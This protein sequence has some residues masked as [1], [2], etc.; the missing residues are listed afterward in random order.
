MIDQENKS[1]AS[2]NQANPN[3]V[4]I[5]DTTLRDGEQ[6]PG[7]SMNIREKIEVGH[8]LARLGVD[9]IEAG[10]PITSPGDFEAVQ[11]IAREIEGPTICALART[12]EKDITRAGEAVAPAKNRRI[13][14]FIAT[15]DVHVEKKLRMSREQVI[16]NA[17]AAV[18]LARTFTDDVE[19]SCE[20]AGRTDWDYMVEVLTAVI[21]AGATTLNIPDTVGY[22]VPEQ[23]GKCIEYVRSKTPGIENCIVSVHCHNDL[24]MAVANTLAGL[25]H[26]ARQAECTVNGIGERAGNA[27]L[28]EIVMMLRVRKDYWGLETGIKTEEIYRASRMVSRITGVRVQPNKAIVGANAFA[29]EAGIHQAGVIRARE[30]YEIMVPEHVGWIGESMV[31]GKHSGRN[32]LAKRLEA[33][34]FTDLSKEDL[35]RAYERFK[36]LCDLKKE[37]FDEDLL[38]IVEDEVLQAQPEYK[39]LDLQVQAAMNQPPQ[40]YLKVA[41]SDGA[42]REARCREG[43][44][45]VDALYRALDSLTDFEVQLLD[46]SIDSVTSGKDAQGRVKVRMMV[47]GREV[48]GIGIAT[49]VIVASALA[50]LSAV[51]RYLILEQIHKNGTATREP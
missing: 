14:T 21:E 40:V 49:D 15:S 4:I 3:R 26:G 48:K 11:Q 29:H 20:D 16:Q 12:L 24:G 31:M 25:R 38:A 22:C 1:Q 9:V 13:H 7:A 43:D 19:F 5:F 44:G 17:A 47:G 8:Q 50:Y 36:K 34:G 39:L 35:E 10:F 41:A 32:A 51:N 42:I 23:F 46:Y 45:Q 18:R 6:S 27:S 37:V 30:T 28:E 2:Q 33:L